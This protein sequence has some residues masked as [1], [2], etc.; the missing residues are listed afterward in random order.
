MSSEKRAAAREKL[1]K[2]AEA[3]LGYKLSESCMFIANSGRYEYRNKGVSIYS[4]IHSENSTVT[5]TWK[6]MRG[7]PPHAGLS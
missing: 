3:V 4:S 1:K 7:F 2:V 6:R 5:Q